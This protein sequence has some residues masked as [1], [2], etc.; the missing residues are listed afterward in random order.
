MTQYSYV[1]KSFDIV[2]DAYLFANRWVHP[3][4][5]LSNE[6]DSDDY[7]DD[8]AA[9]AASKKKYELIVTKRNEIAQITSPETHWTN[10]YVK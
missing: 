5:V 4:S 1:T 8:G 7:N 10:A 2:F 3:L 9:A 6:E